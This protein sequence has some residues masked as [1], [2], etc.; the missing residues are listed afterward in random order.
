MK[1]YDEALN[2]VWVRSPED[3]ARVDDLI[4]KDAGL[5][6]EVATNPR[7]LELI[8]STIPF[9]FLVGEGAVLC[10]MLFTGIRIGLTMNALTLD[11][12]TLMGNTQ[13][14]EHTKP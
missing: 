14:G 1:T 11:E 5:I 2:E 3:I 4:D 7:T 10:S 6:Q 12:A 9:I 13:E 8:E